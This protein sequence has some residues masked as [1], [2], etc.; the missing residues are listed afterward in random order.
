MKI[1]F[2]KDFP[3]TTFI[4]VLF[5]GLLG[6]STST[7]AAN[8]FKLRGTEP[9]STPHALQVWGF[10]QPT[11][12][13]DSSKSIRGSVGGA[14]PLDGTK[15]VPGT[16]PPDRLDSQGFT[17]VRARIG[18]R[19]TMLP[20]N[21]DIDYFVLTEFGKNGIT[22][23]GSAGQL[24]DAS[25]TFNQLSRG[26]DDKGLQN[27]GG[28]IRIGQFLFSQT[29]ESLSHSTPGR[30]IH[31][32]MPE[33]TQAFGLTRL[34]SDNMPGNFPESTVVNGGRDIGLELF[35]WAEF[36]ARSGGPWEF[37]YSLGVSNG[38]TIGEQNRD[39]NFRHYGWLSFAKLFDNTRG[40]RRHDAMIYA[41]YQ[42]GDIE[43]NNDVNNDGIGDDRLG[44]SSGGACNPVDGCNDSSGNNRTTAT[45]A[46]QLATDRINNRSNA[47][48]E[49]QKYWG[50]GVEYFDKPFVNAGQ[51]RFEA[52]YQQQKGL[53]FDGTQSPSSFYNQGLG[54]RYIP[55]GESDG[56]YVGGGYDI[57]QHLG[58]KHRT[59]INLRYDQLNRAKDDT[60]REVTFKTWSLTGEYFFDKKARA[61]LTYQHRRYDADDRT[62]VGSY[63]T[64]GNAA[65]KQI[66]D[67]IALQVTFV[68]KNLLLR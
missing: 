15:S 10:L 43:F 12:T 20:I 1:I 32:F 21:N 13:S 14:V 29:S 19:G 56:F 30:R 22:R 5:V 3:A 33:A 37:T 46:A 53:I 50:I 47:K 16:L 27:L 57:H 6:L 62:D 31:I 38:G 51:I 2:N 61:A 8:W 64:N 59:T 40:P 36:P 60:V 48:N 4:I 26:V 25:V 11:Y 7:E 67:R 63:L 41:F 55:N 17:M 68:F 66:D 34:A 44:A 9:G 23:D 52:E 58:F 42:Q 54:I 35:D 39:G 65:L 28:R 24:L 18:V 45:F 49:K